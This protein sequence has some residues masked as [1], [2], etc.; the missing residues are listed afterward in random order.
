MKN[1]DFDNLSLDDKIKSLLL[2]YGITQEFKIEN[3]E[4]KAMIIMALSQSDII[5][6]KIEED[7]SLYIGYEGEQWENQIE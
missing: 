7:G 5:E 3:E 6:V 1:H 2:K 4:E